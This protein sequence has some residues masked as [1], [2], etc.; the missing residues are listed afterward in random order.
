[1]GTLGI[2]AL[3]VQ[4]SVL[5]GKKKNNTKDGK[6]TVKGKC[7]RAQVVCSTVADKTKSSWHCE[8]I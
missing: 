6:F 7:K 4:G 5:E 3:E 8:A 1:M 2:S